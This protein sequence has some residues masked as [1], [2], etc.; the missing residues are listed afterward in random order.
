MSQSTETTDAPPTAED[1][2]R[3]LAEALSSGP[4]RLLQ[5]LA[6]WSRDEYQDDDDAMV[7]ELLEM[8]AAAAAAWPVDGTEPNPDLP[9]DRLLLAIAALARAMALDI[10]AEGSTP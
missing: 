4:G 9:A 10:L 8:L 6:D 1:R 2:R 7:T 3:A 5:Q